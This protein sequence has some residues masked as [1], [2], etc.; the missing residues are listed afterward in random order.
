MAEIPF[1]EPPPQ[2][3]IALTLLGCVLLAGFLQIVSELA[4]DNLVMRALGDETLAVSLIKFTLA[5]LLCLSSRIASGLQIG[6][7]AGWKRHWLAVIFIWVLPVIVVAILFPALGK[8]DHTYKSMGFWL[9]T[10]IA[11]QLLFSGYIYGQMQFIFGRPAHT[12][13]RALGAAPLVRSFLFALSFWP[14]LRASEPGPVITQMAY[15]FLYS[16]WILNIRR[17]T[18]SVWPCVLNHLLVNMLIAIR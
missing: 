2:W 5:I 1:E 15:A 10:P 12:G 11:Q 16:L 8:P 9:V 4:C 17:W 14:L 13:M 6:D 18:D 3:R 7:R